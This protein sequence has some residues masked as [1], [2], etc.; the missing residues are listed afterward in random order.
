[1]FGRLGL[2]FAGAG[3]VVLVSG[4]CSHDQAEAKLSD[5]W[6]V[7][8]GVQGGS[9]L[10]QPSAKQGEP[11][12]TSVPGQSCLTD[13]ELL[14]AFGKACDH[15]SENPSSTKQPDSGDLNPGIPTVTNEV[16]WYCSG[17]LAVR[18]VLQRCSKTADG[19]LD[20][21]QPVEIAVKTL[22]NH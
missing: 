10:D 7:V 6:V 14:S 16:R 21:V 4:C 20:G 1:M 5:G 11:L 2:G 17:Q 15:E 8:S 22:S 12:A 19:N 9:F 18:V 3:I 13:Q